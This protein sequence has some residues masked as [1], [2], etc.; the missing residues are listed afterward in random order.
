MEEYA[1]LH[2]ELSCSQVKYDQKKTRRKN[3][4]VLTVVASAISDFLP[5]FFFLFFVVLGTELRAS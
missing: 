1:T 2:I 3:S 4:N 5:T